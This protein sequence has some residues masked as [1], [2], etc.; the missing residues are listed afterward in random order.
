MLPS[1]H[2]LTHEKAIG[3]LP[4]SV[5]GKLQEE[6]GR[7][8]KKQEEAGRSR[9]KQVVLGNVGMYRKEQENTQETG[10]TQ[11]KHTSKPNGM[12]VPV[13]YTGGNPCN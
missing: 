6:A 2:A 12:C 10:K 8:R 1:T 7:S 11:G 9:K 13:I 3:A 4:Y 5:F